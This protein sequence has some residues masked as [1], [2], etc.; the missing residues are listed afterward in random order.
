MD[1]LKVALVGAGSRSFGPATVRDVLL[2]ESI[3]QR[4]LTLALMDI[5]PKAL[6]VSERYAKHVADKLGRKVTIQATTSL[7]EALDGTKFVV[8]AVEISRD[9]YWAMDFH[10]P[11]K[12]GFKQIYG[13]NGGPGSLF[14]ALRNMPLI[15]GIAKEME[16]SCPDALLLNYTNPMHKLC[17]AVTRLTKI[18]TIGLCHG[19]WMGMHQIS[20]MLGIPTERLDAP[21]C[22]LNHFTW[23]QSIRDKETGEDLYPRLREIERQGDWLSDWHEIGLSRILFRRFGL[24]PSPGTNHHGEYIGWAEE[25]YASELHWFYDPVDGHPW[26]T[27]KAPEFVYSL[28]GN[29]TGRPFLPP[30]PEPHQPENDEIHFSGELAAPIIEAVGCGEKRELDAINVPNYGAIP[31]LPDETVIEVPGTADGNGIVKTQMKP[32]P[33]AINSLIRT[34]AAIQAV[35]VEAYAEQSKEKLL[36][37]VL[38]EPTVNSYRRAVEMVDEMLRLQKDLLPPL[39]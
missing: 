30:P 23:F 26:E 20:K 31:G 19:V 28:S 8:D 4:D 14:H 24:Y 9:V 39:H 15:M 29:V 22:G 18:Q 17:E 25:F 2:S 7:P 11:R 21:A 38:M 36:Q 3:C 6:E 33:E 10:I 16:R 13:E 12:H 5:D 35:L 32:L 27:G 1:K 37:A 34:Q